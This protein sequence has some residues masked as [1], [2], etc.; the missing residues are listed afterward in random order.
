MAEIATKTVEENI[1]EHMK[2]NGQMM[3]WLSEKIGLS[4]GHL[5]N[6]LKGEGGAKRELTTENL[7]KIN[8]AL[9]TNFK[10]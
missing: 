10:K 4:N 1:L 9:R 6:V 7:A 2:D 8:A 3:T 5:T